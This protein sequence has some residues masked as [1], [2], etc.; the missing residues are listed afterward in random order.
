MSTLTYIQISAYRKKIGQLIRKIN[1]L[2]SRCLFSDQL[3]RG[4][5]GKIFKK[6]GKQNCRCMRDPA[7]RHGPYKV[8]S[9]LKDG[10]QRQLPLSKKKADLWQL[11]IHYQHQM[12]QVSELGKVF[13]ELRATVLKVIEKRL[14]EFP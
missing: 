3:V 13:R 12:K 8:I 14:I 11:A 2:S 6:C 9:V 4:T 5:P 7:L 10:K 1:Y